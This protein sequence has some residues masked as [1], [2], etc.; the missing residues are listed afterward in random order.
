M[1]AIVFQDAGLF[2]SSIEDVIWARYLRPL[3]LADL[4]RFSGHCYTAAGKLVAFAIAVVASDGSPT[5]ACVFYTVFP[6]RVFIQSYQ[7]S[8]SRLCPNNVR[9]DDIKL[10]MPYGVLIDH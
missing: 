8:G 3:K 4:S 1:V 10:K 9:D 5:L 6:V 7:S 2:P